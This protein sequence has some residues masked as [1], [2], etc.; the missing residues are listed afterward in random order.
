MPRIKFDDQDLLATEQLEGGWYVLEV[1]EVSD[2]T[3]GSRDPSS[4]NI[5]IDF[6]VAGPKKIG[7][8]VKH[9]FSEKSLKTSR[10]MLVPYIRCFISDGKVDTSKEYDPVDTKGK[11]VEGYISWNAEMKMNSI[12]EFRRFKAAA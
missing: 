3:P 4:N 1:K 11:K 7:V 12:S 10:D 5:I 8:P 2:W 9:W 6:V